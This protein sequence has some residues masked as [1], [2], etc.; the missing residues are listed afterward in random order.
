MVPQ[1]VLNG[2]IAGGSYVLVAVGFC[3]IYRA[4]RLFHI[5]HGIAFTVGAYTALVASDWM[6]LHLAVATF[7]GVAI[8]VIVELALAVGI[9]RPLQHRG[10]S[11]LAMFVASLGALIFVQSGIAL[12]FGDSARVFRSEYLSSSVG[13]CGA[14]VTRGQLAQ[15]IAGMGLT[16]VLIMWL[17]SSAWGHMV[18]AYGDNPNLAVIRGISANTVQLS[19]IVIG[20]ALAA[21]GGILS[22]LDTDLTPSMG[23]NAILVAFVAMIA[24]GT[25]SL[26]GT[27]VG[28]F[29]VGMLRHIGGWVLPTEWQDTVVYV[30]LA[31]FLFLRP[32]GVMG[33]RPDGMGA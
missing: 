28:A 10:A 18:L 26:I 31:G 6:H 23:F 12:V 32:E 13:L 9:Y 8:A 1:V 25:E 16:T 27:I 29:I 20:S 21:L 24:G 5:A 11:P 2:I 3:L 4:Y 7:I 15:L 22:G 33:R 17:R 19:C 14:L 30:L